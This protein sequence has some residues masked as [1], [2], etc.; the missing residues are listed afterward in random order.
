MPYYVVGTD[1]AKNT[2]TVSTNLTR[3]KVL[4]AEVSAMHWIGEVPTLPADLKIQT[5]YREQP[6][7]AQLEA[8]GTGIL[9]TFE[10]EHRASPGQ[11][12]VAYRGDECLGGGVIS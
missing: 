4:S 2:I 12:L 1:V 11:Y 8:R 7:A 5:R 10:K 3:T 9:A 6:I